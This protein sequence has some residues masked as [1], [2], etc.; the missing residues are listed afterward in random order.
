[1]KGKVGA[2]T[3]MAGQTYACFQQMSKTCDTCSGGKHSNY[4]A[5]TWDK[6]M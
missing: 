2:Y 5:L 4:K 1:M 6:C 3:C